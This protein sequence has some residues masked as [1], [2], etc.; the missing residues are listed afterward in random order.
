L[1]WCQRSILLAIR[2]CESD[3]VPFIVS[4]TSFVKITFFLGLGK[5]LKF[6][7]LLILLEKPVFNAILNVQLDENVQVG[8]LFA[9]ILLYNTIRGES[10]SDSTIERRR[11]DQRVLND[12]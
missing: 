3:A 5:S 6:N 9:L 2:Y 8:V 4:Y 10:D 11:L 12:L 1:P 7:H